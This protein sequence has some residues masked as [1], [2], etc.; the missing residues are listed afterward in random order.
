MSGNNKERG[1]SR[2][3]RYLKWDVM[4]ILGKVSHMLF[5]SNSKCVKGSTL[6]RKVRKRVSITAS[7]LP[8]TGTP[9]G[10]TSHKGCLSKTRLSFSQHFSLGPE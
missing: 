4:P 10:K 2:V 5:T 1:K 7:V 9:A 6:K 3:F 8:T